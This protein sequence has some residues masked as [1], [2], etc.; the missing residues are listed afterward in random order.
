MVNVYK[1]AIKHF[2]S[3]FFSLYRI[4]DIVQYSVDA[5]YITGA[6]FEDRLGVDAG[7]LC[8]QT[9]YFNGLSC[10]R[11]EQL[12][13]SGTWRGNQSCERGK[14]RK[15]AQAVSHRGCNSPSGSFQR[16]LG[17]VESSRGS[18]LAISC[19]CGCCRKG[20]RGGEQLEKGCGSEDRRIFAER[21]QCFLWLP[22]ESP[23]LME[24]SPA[25][26]VS[27]GRTGTERNHQA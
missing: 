19:F 4:F 16:W 15:F 21:G 3:V 2:N 17:I 8:P 11:Q 22:A 12:G 7:Q 18:F 1:Y 9:L 5:V 27:P 25:G 20:A 23:P 26:G 13:E 24:W 6:L 14:S 10:P